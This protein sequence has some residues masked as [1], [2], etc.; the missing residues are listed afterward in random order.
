MSAAPPSNGSRRAGRLGVAAVLFCA[1]AVLLPDRYA[2]TTFH[3]ANTAGRVYAVQAYVHYGTWSLAPILCRTGPGHSIVDLSVRDDRPY[4]QKAPGASWAGIP[5]YAVLS[6]AAG[7]VRLPFH[8][9][10]MALGLLCVGLPLTLSALAL[11]RAW[12]SEVGARPATLAILAMLLA[13][14][15]HTYA[16]MFQ[17]YPLAVALLMG[18]WVLARRHDAG[19]MV[20]GGLLMGAAGVTNYAFFLYAGVAAAVEAWRRL[21]QGD[22]AARFIASWAAG[23]ALPLA[24][25][26]A[27]NALLFGGPLTTAYAYMSDAGQRAAHAQVGFSFEALVRSLI[28]PKHG[29]F[30][31]A[32]WTLV[33]LAGLV[34]ALRDR[35]RQWTAMTGLAV[36][37]AVLAFSSI[38][39]T[40]NADDMAFNRHVMAVFPWMAWGLGYLI[41][42]VL[43]GDSV[44]GRALLGFAAAGAVMG[45]F[46]ALATSWTFPYH[47]FQLA[48][49]IWQIN[50]PLFLNGGHVQSILYHLFAP[51]AVPGREAAGAHWGPVVATVL[52]AGLAWAAALAIPHPGTA[53]DVQAPS[54]AGTSNRL[55]MRP[56]A[57]AAALMAGIYLLAGIGLA[58]CPV[59]PRQRAL[60]ESV[61]GAAVQGLPP[62][63]REAVRQVRLEDRF[64]KSALTDILGSSFTPQDVTWKE[65]GYPGRNRWCD[66]VESRVPARLDAPGQVR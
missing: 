60:A 61:Q 19:A 11:R 27:Y 20:A 12:A 10:S 30:H 28:G 46:Y 50:I 35:P 14:P 45:W 3:E 7:G 54:D 1:A 38:W 33:G 32:P 66:S 63:G 42:R 57:F 9:T 8:W 58:G 41:Q 34:L 59:G 6:A 18:G 31:V 51:W 2:I 44:P 64:Y 15:L 53:G 29:I 24:A 62:K 48:T 13:S 49:P 36:S 23:F 43:S 65:G 5:V 26:L 21:A 56:W 22:R 16:G 52:A 47:A 40:S 25:L 37:V 17:D 4:L 39:E 55:R